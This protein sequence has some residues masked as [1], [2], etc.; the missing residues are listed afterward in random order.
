MPK[1]YWLDAESLPADLD[2]FR[3]EHAVT[4][5]IASERF[6]EVAQSCGASDVVFKEVATEPPGQRARA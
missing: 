3:L 2:V 4:R 5:F 6:V 1:E